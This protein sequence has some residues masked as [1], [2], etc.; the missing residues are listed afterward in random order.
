MGPKEQGVEGS[1]VMLMQSGGSHFYQSPDSSESR[2][3]KS[4]TPQNQSIP[5]PILADLREKEV[6]HAE[7]KVEEDS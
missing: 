2:Q 4:F 5:K 7:E 6:V 1:G 3:P